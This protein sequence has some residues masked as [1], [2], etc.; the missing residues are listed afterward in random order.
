MLTFSS[1]SASPLVRSSLTR[2][3]QIYFIPTDYL[4]IAII[5]IGLLNFLQ[6]RKYVGKVAIFIEM[7]FNLNRGV[8]VFD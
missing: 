5:S 4:A 6:T 7:N 2:Y 3:P 8:V 1:T